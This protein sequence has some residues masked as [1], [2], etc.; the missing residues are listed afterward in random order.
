MLIT[1]L[2][3]RDLAELVRCCLYAP[4]LD[5]TVVFGASNNRDQRW[6]DNSGAAHLGFKPQ[7]DTEAY[8]ASI[9]ATEKW[10]S[11]AP[12]SRFMGGMYVVAGPYPM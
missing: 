11:D 1:W 6:W 8:R 5:H 12:Q 2:S 10:P 4:K 3:Y 9:E 7:D